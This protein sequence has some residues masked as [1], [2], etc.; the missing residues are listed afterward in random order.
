MKRD[1]IITKSMAPA[2]SSISGRA[3]AFFN[4]QT[5]KHIIKKFLPTI[6]K[7]QNVPPL[8]EI[9]LYDGPGKLRDKVAAELVKD[10]NASGIRYAM[11]AIY[12]GASNFAAAEELKAIV[13][14][15][16]QSPLFEEG[17]PFRGQIFYNENGCS[18]ALE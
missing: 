6:R 2:L 7:M 12:P 15:S 8:V 14:Q 9:F 5:P 13:N 11:K 18:I 4:C 17:E 16:Y 3:Y 1:N 10:A